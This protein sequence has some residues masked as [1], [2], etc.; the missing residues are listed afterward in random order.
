MLHIG[1]ILNPRIEGRSLF[2][3]IDISWHL[4]LH[5][6]LLTLVE[7]EPLSYTAVDDENHA[8]VSKGGG[9]EAKRICQPTRTKE[10]ETRSV[11]HAQNAHH[12]PFLKGATGRQI[13]TSKTVDW[14]FF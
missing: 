5:M 4:K 3:E 8:S 6:T 10:P 7:L 9:E 11:D 1:Q 13:L 14:Q 12:S 2:L